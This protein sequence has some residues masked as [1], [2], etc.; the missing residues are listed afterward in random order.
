M[1][2]AREPLAIRAAVVAAIV[3]I[4]DAL[5]AFNALTVTSDQK[6]YLVG[7]INLTSIAVLAVW[8]RGAVTPNGSVAAID[9][10]DGV[11]PL[12][13]PA[14]PVPNDVPVVVKVDPTVEGADELTVGP[15]AGKHRADDPKVTKPFT[16]YW[17]GH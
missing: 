5:I 4:L 7:A 16:G 10:G 12:A 14:S 9:K 11:G 13:G 2:T 8:T 15:Y 1:N 17:G 6:G 3:A